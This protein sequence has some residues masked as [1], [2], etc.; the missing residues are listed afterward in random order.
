[1]Q[2][3]LLTIEFR[4][5]DAPRGDWDGPS[6]NKIVTIG[7]FDTLEEAVKEGNEAL[8]ALSE[9]FQVRADDRFYIHGLSGKPNRLVTNVCY[10][11]KGISY[12]A[13]IT[14]LKFDDLAKTIKETFQA[15]ERFKQYKL[16]KYG[17][18]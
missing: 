8:K 17:W 15:Y 4:Y 10:T 13:K 1:M 14:P 12:F 7:V 11:T 16:K 6:R 3:E 18:F 2:K 9:H 5:H